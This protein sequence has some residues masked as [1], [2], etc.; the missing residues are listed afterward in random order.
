[1]TETPN[2]R[3]ST[4]QLLDKIPSVPCL[5]RHSVN[6]TYYGI[7]KHAGKRKEHSLDT[8]DRKIAERKLRG[9]ISDLA[10]ID[11]ELEKTTLAQL[12]EK[13]TSVRS[14]MKPSTVR[15]DASIIK[16]LKSHWKHGLD[17]RVSRIRPSMLD[18][19]LAAVEPDLKNSSFNR[20]TQLVKQLFDIALNDKMIS[21]SPHPNLRTTWKRP[22]KPIRLVPTDEQFQAIVADIRNQRLNAESGQSADF[23]EFLGL[24]GLGQAEASWLTWQRVNFQKG[25]HG[26]LTV[27]RMK[28]G[29]LYYIPIYAHLKPFLTKLHARQTTPPTPETNLFTISDAK[30]SLTNA[31]K[32]LGYPHFTQ[33]SIRAYLIRRLWQSGV[34]IKLI[35]KWQGHQDGGRLILNTYTE[36]FG[37]N[38]AEYIKS[39]LAN[40][41]YKVQMAT[42]F[43]AGHQGCESTPEA[44]AAYISHT[45][46]PALLLNQIKSLGWLDLAAALE[47]VVAERTRKLEGRAD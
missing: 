35:S 8:T 33:R 34:D 27:R 24:A 10:K 46:H 13:F 43:G 19:W 38:D 44:V 18:E 22:Q 16:S 2:K 36:V 31:C 23:I 9:W 4:R 37:T 21:E 40:Q 41:R 5:Y 7:K 14:G 15:T 47:T 1:M 42:L 11:T 25:E 26:E 39:E 30:K 28:T 20:Y 3:P 45:K 32:R 17:I 29:E 6:G 12:L